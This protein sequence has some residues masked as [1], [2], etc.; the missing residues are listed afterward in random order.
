M[1]LPFFWFCFFDFPKTSMARS[2][3]SAVQVPHPRPLVR[4]PPVRRYGFMD[5]LQHPESDLHISRK[6][7]QH[8]LIERVE[9]LKAVE[10][11]GPD[12]D[13][14]VGDGEHRP[15]ERRCRTEYPSHTRNLAHAQTR[16]GLR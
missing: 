12:G 14:D 4:R 1:A 15:N 11:L 10:S 8:V 6:A 9:L 7:C 2:G 5:R 3:I 13:L 16:A